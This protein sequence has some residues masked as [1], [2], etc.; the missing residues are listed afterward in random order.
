[1]TLGPNDRNGSEAVARRLVSALGGKRTL[2]SE[3][4]VGDVQED[5]GS[6]GNHN[7][8]K[9]RWGFH[10]RHR[11]VVRRERACPKSHGE[12]S[13]KQRHDEDAEDA[14]DH[15]GPDDCHSGEHKNGQRATVHVTV[16][17]RRLMSAMGRKQT[18][19]LASRSL[20]AEP[21]SDYLKGQDD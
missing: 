21:C 7:Q 2:A 20:I 3:K 16:L 5:D 17:T 18:S 10:P 14:S 9:L 8:P 6:A 11:W 4:K 13:S 19:S 1:M 15:H 12:R